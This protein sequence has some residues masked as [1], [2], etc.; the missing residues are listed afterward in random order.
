MMDMKFKKKFVKR[1]FHVGSDILENHVES[2]GI[3]HFRFEQ[4][5]QR[6]QRKTKNDFKAMNFFKTSKYLS[7]QYYYFF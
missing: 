5:K 4:I 3:I 2:A 7:M 1:E 6:K